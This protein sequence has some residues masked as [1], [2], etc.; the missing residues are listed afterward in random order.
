M[1]Y[2]C[3]LLLW[4]DPK[5]N[6]FCFMTKLYNSYFENLLV[7]LVIR[8]CFQLFSTRLVHF[9]VTLTCYDRVQRS[10]GIL[11]F[12]FRKVDVIKFCFLTFVMLLKMSIFIEFSSCFHVCCQCCRSELLYQSLSASVNQ[13]ITYDTKCFLPASLWG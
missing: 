6:L 3:G 9:W 5:I 8:P 12:P 7:P 1:S 4:K 13:Y 11:L 2:P 10:Q